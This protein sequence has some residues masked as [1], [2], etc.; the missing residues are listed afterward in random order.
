[1]EDS[2]NGIPSTSNSIVQPVQPI[3]SPAEQRVANFILTAFPPHPEYHR[4]TV[5][6]E[7]KKLESQRKKVKA[8]IRQKQHRMKLMMDSL[9]TEERQLDD[10]DAR[11]RQLKSENVD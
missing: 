6:S 5:M 10:I 2:G 4:E 8:N 1:M 3:L 7:I 9:K 11:L